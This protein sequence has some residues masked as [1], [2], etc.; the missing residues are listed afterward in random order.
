M[1]I[2]EKQHRED[3]EHEMAFSN[4]MTKPWESCYTTNYPPSPYN[5]Y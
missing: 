4:E 3:R 1:E 2:E 5:E